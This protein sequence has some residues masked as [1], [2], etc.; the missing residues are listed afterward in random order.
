M[1]IGGITILK[2]AFIFAKRALTE[3][4]KQ[5]LGRDVKIL[6]I[7][8]ISFMSD[9]QFQELDKRL[10]VLRDKNKPFG[11]FLIIFAGDFFQLDPC[12]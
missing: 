4:N 10:K 6:I 12:G 1:E 2:A 7:N 5:V 8:E 9:R 3:K 11:G